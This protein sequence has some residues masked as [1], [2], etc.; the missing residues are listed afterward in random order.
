MSH[1]PNKAVVYV[2]HC[3]I[4]AE[5]G[6]EFLDV[7]L[8]KIPRHLWPDITQYKHLSDKLL[9]LV[10]RLLIRRSLKDVGIDRLED[11]AAWSRDGK[12]DKP[13]LSGREVD[14]SITHSEHWVAV[15]VSRKA[16]VGLDLEMVRTVDVDAIRRYL[17]P[18]ELAQHAQA[19]DPNRTALELWCQKEAILKAQGSGLMASDDQIRDIREQQFSK[20]GAWHLNDLS[21]DDI[22]LYLATDSINPKIIVEEF[23][24]GELI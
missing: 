12:H 1:S 4:P 7:G 6:V 20:S 11:L 15:A 22:C 8:E 9:R 24:P 2:Y 23:Q 16:K 14:F 19:S 5:T 3:R 13:Y 10:G 18:T 17:T 21:T